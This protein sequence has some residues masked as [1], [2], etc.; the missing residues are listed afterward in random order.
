MA[1]QFHIPPGSDL[2][3]TT[4]R[5]ALVDLAPVFQALE[6]RKKAAQQELENQRL[7]ERMAMDQ[8][9]LGFDEQR[10]GLEAQRA[11]DARK[12]LDLDILMK[13]DELGYRGTQREL[14]RRAMETEDAFKRRQMEQLGKKPEDFRERVIRELLG[15]PPPAP[16]SPAPPSGPVGPFEG[17]GQ[18]QGGLPPGDPMPSVPGVVTPPTTPTI[19]QLAPPRQ[20]APAPMQPTQGAPAVRPSPQPAQTPAGQDADPIVDTPFGPRRRSQLPRIEGLLRAAQMD[21]LANQIKEI[22]DGRGKLRP[23]DM[24]QIDEADDQV[25]AAQG[26]LNN[27]KRARTLNQPTR[28]YDGVGAE[29]RAWLVNNTPI[30]SLPLVDDKRGIDTKE[31]GT[32]TKDLA[33]SQLKSIFGAAPTEGERKILMEVQ[34][35]VNEPRDSR[36]RTLRKAEY[37]ANRR[38]EY[39]RRKAAAVRDGSYWLPNGQISIGPDPTDEELEKIINPKADPKAQKPGEAPQRAPGAP[40]GRPSSQPRAQQDPTIQPLPRERQAVQQ[41]PN[42]QHIE[43]LMRNPTPEMKK[44][45]NEKFGPNAAD[46]VL[47]GRR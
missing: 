19:T 28:A 27:L 25:Q 21:S 42:P 44:A 43:A 34:G 12:A 29:E 37:F 41:T 45:F 6:A 3:E 38:L 11:A 4:R 31:F 46:D 47:K 24:K 14:T 39:N 10:L 32:L 35:A 7:A 33:L 18:G 1:V 13:R 2:V 8:K 23:E 9:R 20:P 15:E 17:R 40:I 30:G 22:R 5:N 36:E 16:N 26:T